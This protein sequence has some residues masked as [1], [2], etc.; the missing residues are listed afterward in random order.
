MRQT[1]WNT[2]AS[3]IQASGGRHVWKLMARA[4]PHVCKHCVL[5][6][7]GLRCQ[8]SASASGPMLVQLSCKNRG[9]RVPLRKSPLRVLLLCAARS[10][11]TRCLLPARLVAATERA[12]L[13]L[14][15]A[16]SD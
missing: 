6:W 5:V 7:F 16:C 4:A 3:R 8:T 9:A 10:T 14:A 11:C 1:M 12:F 15:H 13:T 2:L